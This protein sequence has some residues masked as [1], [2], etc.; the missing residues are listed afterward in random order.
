[1]R[2]YFFVLAF[3]L[4]LS[5]LNA[6][7]FSIKGNLISNKQDE[8]IIGAAI[9]LIH[10]PDS[11]VVKGTYSKLENNRNTFELKAKQGKYFLKISYLA[12]KEKIVN[13]DL[14]KDV[15]L[16]NILLEEKE[17]NLD[18]IVVTGEKQYLELQLDKKVYN[19]SKDE[20]NKGRNVSDLLDNIPSVTVDADGSV[21]LKGSEGVRILVDGKQSGLV[22][23]DPE[24]LRM[25]SGDLVDKIEV[26]TNP[27]AKYD[28]EGQ[29]G[30]I[31]IV[32]KKEQQ[33]GLNGNTTINTGYPD[34][35]GLSLSSN[36]RASSYNLFSS[37]GINYNMFPGSAKVEQ[38][39][40]D[41]PSKYLTRTDRDQE[42]GGT[43]G[44]IRFGSDFFLND[45]NTL[46]AT[47]LYSY[48]LRDN[49]TNLTY[50]DYNKQ[51]DLIS[52]SDRTDNEN[53]DKSTIEFALNYMLK[54]DDNGHELTANTNFVQDN[55]LEQS[56]I[57]QNYNSNNVPDLFQ[58]S[59]NLQFERNQLYQIDYKLP[60]SKDGKFETGIKSQ[61][62]KIN[63]DYWL[64]KKDENGN[65]IFDGNYNNNFIYNEDI[66]AGYIMASD[67]M[68]DFAWQAG[69]RGE[70]SIIGTELTKTNFTNPR[71]YFN[72]FPS[73]HLS[74][75][76]NQLSSIQTGYSRRLDRPRFWFLM[77]VMGFSDNRNFFTGNPNLNPEYSNSFDLG[78]LLNWEKGTILTNLY[79]RHSTNT[80]QRVT[81]INENGVTIIMPE[82]I[83][84][85]DDM[86]AELNISYTAFK[87]WN[88]NFNLNSFNAKIIGN[89]SVGS[90]NSDSWVTNLKLNNKFKLPWDVNFSLN[91]S[92]RGPM[93]LPQGKMLDIWFVDFAMSKDLTRDITLTFTGSDVFSTRMRKMVTKDVSYYFN[94]DF[95]WRKGLF[96][97]SF[98]YRLNQ[99][100]KRESGGDG[101]GGNYEEG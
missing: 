5:F 21:S 61:L 29:V 43:K 45:N 38:Y 58:K 33:K 88:M 49:Y 74:Y 92:Y 19:V 24:A 87:W 7:E 97:L 6:Q 93:N 54:F 86:G 34:N 90:L 14:T 82:N 76:F 3:L 67:K 98:S 48:T 83:G 28:A 4:S 72:L 57:N 10:L 101:G 31:N 27:S 30:I 12:F 95:Q 84:N 91:Y 69:L 70:Y 100:K 85:R 79:Y 40:Y 13:I 23:R 2:S 64:K 94:Q 26:I 50:D 65:Y 37:V 36:Y 41:S 55:E 39:F 99:E 75:K 56:N 80:I 32:L 47:G 8:I 78:Y 15:V 44:T 81:S 51:D 66:H 62:K 96:T 42:M 11:N 89:S 18:E 77:P 9:A 52:S 71:N 59:R 35:H 22:G 53:E 60:F 25:L 68:S 16:N 1:M 17:I 63:N 20:T 73:L 46:T